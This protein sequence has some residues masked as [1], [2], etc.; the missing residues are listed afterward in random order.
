MTFATGGA[1]A[2][3]TCPSQFPRAW[4]LLTLKK[5]LMVVYL[6]FKFNCDSYIFIC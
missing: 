2:P 5:E 3:G 6:K 4:D 1:P